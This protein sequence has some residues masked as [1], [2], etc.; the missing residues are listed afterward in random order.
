MLQGEVGEPGQKGAKGGKGE[1]VS[2]PDVVSEQ[3]CF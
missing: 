1:H 3:I 2:E